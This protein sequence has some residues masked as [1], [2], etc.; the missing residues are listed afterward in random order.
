MNLNDIHRGIH[1]AKPRKRL[2]R[3]I[4]SGQGKTAGRGH[5]GQWSHNGVSFLAVFQG[6]ASPLV[7]RIPKRGFNNRWAKTV[8][9]VNLG[10]LDKAFNAG[11]EVT[12]DSLAKSNLAKGVYDEIKILGDGELTKKLKVSAHRFSN[13]AKEKIAAAGGEAIVLPGKAPVVKNKTRA[14]AGS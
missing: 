14:K 5:K 12:P 8:L 2:G 11:D 3:G 1:K 13:S 7:R 9:I 10:A 6:G 4:G